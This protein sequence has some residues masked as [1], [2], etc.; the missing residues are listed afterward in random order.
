MMISTT[1]KLIGGLSALFASLPAVAVAAELLTLF[2]PTEWLEYVVPGGLLLV[3]C[4]SLGAM[5]YL[6]ACQ[7]AKR[8]SARPLQS[9]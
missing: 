8:L 5:G 1:T 7:V 3:I 2:R 9:R 4:L 6:V